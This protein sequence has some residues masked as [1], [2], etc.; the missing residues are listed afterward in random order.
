MTDTLSTSAAPAPDFADGQPRRLHP[1]TLVLALLRVGPRS[2]NA[3]PALIAIGITG[4]WQ[5]IIPA[6][7]LFLAVSLVFAWLSWLRFTWQ[8]DADDIAINS[9]VFSRNSRTI[10]FDR[11]QDVAI[12]QGLLARLLG[13]A[14]VGFDTGSAEADGAE[15]G[16]LRSISLTDAGALR[17]HI[18]SHR[19]SLTAAPRI[20]PPDAHIELPAAAVMPVDGPLVYAMSPRRLVTAGLFNFSLVFFA[21]LL[22]VLSRFDDILPVNPF[23]FDV[24][25]E[26]ARSL[27]IERWVLGHR[28]LAALG[29]TISVVVLG[30]VT[31]VIRTAIKDWNFRL[32]RNARGFRR[33]RGLTTRTDVVIPI[34]RVQAAVVESDILRQYFGWYAVKLQSLASDTKDEADHVIAPFATL[35]ECD[36]LLGALQFDRGGFEE[37]Q[38]AEPWHGS[39]PVGLFILPA[40]LSVGGVIHAAAMILF[41]PELLWTSS[42]VVVLVLLSLIASWFAWHHRRWHFDGQLLHITGGFLRRRHFILPARHIQSADL[43]IGPLRRRLSLASLTFG[44]AGGKG[45]SHGIDDLPLEQARAL[46][47]ALLAVRA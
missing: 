30:T 18:R 38:P 42:I 16:K 4:K 7:L 34:A 26:L 20:A 17:D 46:R 36:T 39:H 44:V 15:E 43:S 6:L 32:E 9:G 27:G 35:A 10:P 45:Q 23:D 25:L 19:Q 14:T 29:G 13:V 37:G 40:C 31:G 3:L 41:K 11:I 47:D 33:T 28:W 5:W 24:W 8:V 12:E 21:V 22:G 1:L 2:A